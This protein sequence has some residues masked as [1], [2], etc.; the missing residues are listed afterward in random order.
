VPKVVT[1]LVGRC[2]R[3]QSGV[4]AAA[5]AYTPRGALRHRSCLK[6]SR[7]AGT[8]AKPRGGKPPSDDRRPREPAE[9]AAFVKPLADAIRRRWVTCS[10]AVLRAGV[11]EAKG[12]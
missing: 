4:T 8:R 9:V 3:C 10:V 7:S 5:A 1:G 11:G 2:S 12:G 6:R